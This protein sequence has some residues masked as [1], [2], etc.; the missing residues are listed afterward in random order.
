MK[1]GIDKKTITIEQAQEAKEFAKAEGEWIDKDVLKTCA[2]KVL[3]KYYSDTE[4]GFTGWICIDEVISTGKVE[5]S[6]D[7]WKM[8]VYASDVVVKFW[9]HGTKF[10]IV[11]MNVQDVAIEDNVHSYVR[12]FGETDGRVI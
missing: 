12:I 8:C 7:H 3:T 6:I 2:G 10:A 11:S 4:E 9:Q 1:I 5:V